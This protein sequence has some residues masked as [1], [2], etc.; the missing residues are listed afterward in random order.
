MAAPD[1]TLAPPPSGTTVQPTEAV[2][3]GPIAAD[4]QSAE[5]AWR[6]LAVK[7]AAQRR[8]LESGAAVDLEDALGSLRALLANPQPRTVASAG[9][10]ALR[11]ELERLALAL[12]HAV[13]TTGRELGE[14]DRQRRA[15]GAYAAIA[16]TGPP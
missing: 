15:L 10:L 14:L 12:S 4:D 16:R 7:V 1:G 2:G 6:D 3:H 9:G 13:E 11:D 8:R 5:A